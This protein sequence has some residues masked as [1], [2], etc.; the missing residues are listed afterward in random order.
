MSKFVRE[1]CAGYGGQPKDNLSIIEESK[2]EARSS[3]AKPT[4]KAEPHRVSQYIR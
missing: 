2:S 3:S 4:S 1:S